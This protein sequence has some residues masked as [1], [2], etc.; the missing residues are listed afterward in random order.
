MTKS[1]PIYILGG[2]TVYYVRPHLALSAPA[3]GQTARDIWH[4]IN[5]NWHDRAQNM[6]LGLTTMAI[7]ESY[8]ASYIGKTNSDVRFWLQANLENPSVVFLN[9]AFCDYEGTVEDDDA[10]AHGSNGF[11]LKTSEG[12]KTMKL[13]P[14]EKIVDELRKVHKD[15]FLV[16][17]KTTS[18]ASKEEMFEAGAKLL[19]RASCNLVMVNDISSRNN[20]IVT[21]ELACY[22]YG[23]GRHVVLKTLVDMAMER[24]EGT[25]SR[26]ERK[27][28][29]LLSIKDAPETFRTVLEACISAGAYEAFNGKTVGHFGFRNT[30]ETNGVG[31]WSSRRKRNYNLP[32]ET[33]LIRVRADDSKGTIEA[34][35]PTA[36]QK[37]SA[38]ARSQLHVLNKF[39]ELDCIIHFHCPLKDPDDP[40]IP[41]RSQFSF[42]CGSN[43]CGMNTADG[44]QIVAPGIAAVMLEKHGPN[45]CFSSKADPQDIID[46]IMKHFDLTKRAQ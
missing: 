16:A 37:P 3:Y 19:K 35:S 30:N 17:W 43:E 26:T 10:R 33:D 36:D 32:G 13:V 31:M 28:G 21:P 2:G 27:V 25:F 45:I 5:T 23:Q 7:R 41:R 11:R 20:M 6:C 22:G 34:W 24:S 29:D 9:V 40:V 46:F 42:E 4:L 8:A 38:G 14:S 12:P 44:M 15:I 18:N 1:K 39:P